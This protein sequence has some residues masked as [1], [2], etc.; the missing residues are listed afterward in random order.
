[1]QYIF[2]PGTTALDHAIFLSRRNTIS[3][4]SQH[5]TWFRSAA[6]MPSRYSVPWPSFLVLTPLTKSLWNPSVFMTLLVLLVNWCS[7]SVK[8]LVYR[9]KLFI[10]NHVLD[11]KLAG[12]DVVCQ[13]PF[14]SVN[15]K[16]SV[17]SVTK[18]GI[19]SDTRSFLLEFSQLLRCRTRRRILLEGLL[20][21]PLFKHWQLPVINTTHV[22]TGLPA[23]KRS[24]FFPVRPLQMRSAIIK[25]W[26]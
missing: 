6:V 17:S 5:S 18:I 25:V 19:L 3:P 15:R 7:Q 24:V 16:E 26:I 13:W 21:K 2:I 14:F 8:I 10:S 12:Y 9:W 11:N 4:F 20:N 22:F 23:C 1:M